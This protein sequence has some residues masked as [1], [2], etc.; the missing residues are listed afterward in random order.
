MPI[1]HTRRLVSRGATAPLNKLAEAVCHGKEGIVV[2]IYT[3][4]NKSTQIGLYSPDV[5]L[6]HWHNLDGEVGENK[7]Y[8][9]SAEEL[10]MC[11]Q[12]GAS[13]YEI[14]KPIEHRG[15]QLKGMPCKRLA[16]L[17]DG[18]IFVEFEQDVNGCSA[19]GL[20]KAGH[21]VAVNT[22]ALKVMK[23]KEKHAK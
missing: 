16:T 13:N 14:A 17:E 7:G 1:H 12:E 6:P 20:G 11:I 3:I 5:R 8:W 9:V 18:S 22:S 15:V 4:K 2:Q 19:D 10:G 23:K 21:C